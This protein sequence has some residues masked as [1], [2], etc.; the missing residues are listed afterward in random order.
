MSTLTVSVATPAS[1]SVTRNS[2]SYMHAPAHACEALV[3]KSRGL[4][5]GL[6][7]GSAPTPTKFVTGGDVEPSSQFQNHVSSSLPGS[8]TRVVNPIGTPSSAKNV[9]TPFTI[10][11]PVSSI[12]AVG[13]T[14]ATATTN[15]SLPV[16]PSSSVTL[17]VTVNE[18]LSP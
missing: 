1:S 4:T 16:P 3:R 15:E 7:S 13:L 12:V 8:C 17:T 10:T 5:F 18:P 9:G 2:G 6:G 14:F 11:A